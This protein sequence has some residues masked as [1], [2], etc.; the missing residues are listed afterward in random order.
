MKKR[1]HAVFL[2]AILLLTSV[3]LAVPAAAAGAVTISNVSG[4]VG[5]LVEVEVR[6][7]SDDVGSGNF[8]LRYDSQTLELTDSVTNSSYFCVANTY[9]KGCV[10]V[11][12]MSA[13]VIPDAL[14]CTLTFR[15]TAATDAQNGSPIVAEQ[16]VLYDVNS[17]LVTSTVIHGA[18]VR[19]TVRLSISASDTAEF[20]SVRAEIS[21]GGSLSPA[22]GNFSVS[23]DPECFSVKS[24]VGLGSM[25]EAIFAYR[26]VEPGLVKVSFGGTAALEPGKFCALV[27][28]TV[29]KAGSSSNLTITDVKMYDEDSKPMDVSVGN[30]SLNIVVPSDEDPKLWVVGGAMEADGTAKASVVLQGRGFVCGGNFTLKYD[31]AM[32]A[33]VTPSANCQ[34]NHDAKTGTVRVSWASDVPYSGEETLLTLEFSNA[35]ESAI[36]L[37]SVTAYVGEGEPVTVVDIRPGAVTAASEVAAMV[38][39]VQKKTEEDGKTAYTVSVDV[40]DGKFFTD[41]AAESLSVMMGLYQDGKMVGVAVVPKTEFSNG[42]S[43]VELSATTGAAVTELRVFLLEDMTSLSPLC[44]ALSENIKDSKE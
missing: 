19:K 22:G 17:S 27:F 30:G 2:A 42:I 23:Y 1:I 29:G 9:E 6:L 43:Q 39:D 7:T 36:T 31:S 34:I 16:M 26:I 24:V 44:Q 33:T 11:G 8:L 4:A 25:E 21:L 20:Q 3:V 13:N 35:K 18:V 15:V 37:D 10:K 41:D 28:Q 12:F 14:L 5:E 38:D 32:T 40:A